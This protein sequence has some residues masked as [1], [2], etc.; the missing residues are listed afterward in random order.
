MYDPYSELTGKTTLPKSTTLQNLDIPAAKKTGSPLDTD[1]FKEAIAHKSKIRDAGNDLDESLWIST[2]DPV[3][4]QVQR[5]RGVRDQGQ[6]HE[7]RHSLSPVDVLKQE[8]QR[9]SDAVPALWGSEHD[10]GTSSRP[11][12]CNTSIRTELFV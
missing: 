5:Q 9:I 8:E 6:L 1:N 2:M 10:H 4:D 12:T 7:K 11:A 3:L